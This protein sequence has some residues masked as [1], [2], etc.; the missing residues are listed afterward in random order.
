MRIGKLERD[1]EV[2]AVVVRLKMKGV[3]DTLGDA[4]EETVILIAIH[5][6]TMRIVTTLDQKERGK[7]LLE[8]GVAAAESTPNIMSLETGPLQ[9]DL[10]MAVR[11]NA[12]NPGGIN[13]KGVEREL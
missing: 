10:V 4:G 11:R 3:E 5:P 7:N 6:V 1:A 8:K 12:W 13:T 2:Q 9:V